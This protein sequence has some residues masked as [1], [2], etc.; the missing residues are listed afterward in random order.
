MIAIPP[1]RICG[2]AAL[3]PVPQ[4]QRDAEAVERGSVSPAQ[5]TASQP[6]VSPKRGIGAGPVL[7]THCRSATGR[8]FG[9]SILNDRKA[10]MESRVDQVQ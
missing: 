9:V 2:R 5:P 6:E 1:P 10:L 4:V 8:S 7:Q 3:T